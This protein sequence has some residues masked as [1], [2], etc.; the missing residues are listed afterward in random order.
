MQNCCRKLELYLKRIHHV[1]VYLTC[2]QQM[3]SS[4]E[5]YLENFPDNHVTRKFSKRYYIA[6]DCRE[7]ILSLKCGK[8]QPSFVL[9]Y[10]I[11]YYSDPWGW[12]TCFNYN[13]GQCVLDLINLTVLSALNVLNYL[14]NKTT[15]SSL[16]I[17]GCNTFSGNLCQTK[18]PLIIVVI[19]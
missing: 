10:S 14:W 18:K 5:C 4:V 1:F 16:K 7:R 9:Q 3:R 13:K 8:E 12:S 6:L 15:V 2:I 17:L 11:Q 19:K